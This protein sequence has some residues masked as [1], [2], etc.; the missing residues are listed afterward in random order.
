LHAFIIK[1]GIAAVTL[2]YQTVE[3]LIILISQFSRL[4]TDKLRRCNDKV[5]T[6]EGCERN[7]YII[8]V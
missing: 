7:N 8:K 3:Y 1:T 4:S 6:V 5:I 2:N